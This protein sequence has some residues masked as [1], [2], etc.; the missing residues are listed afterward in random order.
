MDRACNVHAGCF[1]ASRLFDVVVHARD[2][3]CRGC[4]LAPFQAASRRSTLD[5]GNLLGAE[6]TATQPNTTEHKSAFGRELGIIPGPAI[7]IAVI[8][9]IC[10]PLVFWQLVWSQ[11]P[12][13][14]AWPWRI[15][16]S[17]LP[18]TILAFLVLMVGYVNADAGRRGMSRALWT[19]IVIL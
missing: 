3:S 8:V 11:E 2:V 7:L 19:L 4:G 10:I 9:F 18:A 13:P 14:L 17:V 12:N 1:V 16:I 15:L 5:D 6:M